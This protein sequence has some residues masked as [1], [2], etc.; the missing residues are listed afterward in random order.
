MQQAVTISGEGDVLAALAEL[1]EAHGAEA[2]ERESL[3]TEGALN[4]GLTAQDV[5]TALEIVT[6]L[7]KAGTALFGFLTAARAYLRESNSTTALTL[8]DESG[9]VRGTLTATTSDAQVRALAGP[10]GCTDADP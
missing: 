8:R 1:A 5:H 3:G 10:Q 2:S 9:V 7:F 4:A 6:L